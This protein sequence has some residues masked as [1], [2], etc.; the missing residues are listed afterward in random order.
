MLRGPRPGQAP[1]AAHHGAAAHAEGGPAPASGPPLVASSGGVP[2]RVQDPA[3]LRE[4]GLGG[5]GSGR[6]G[7]NAGEEWDTHIHTHTHIRVVKSI[8]IGER[9]ERACV[10]AQRLVGRALRLSSAH[11]PPQPP[12]RQRRAPPFPRRRPLRLRTHQPLRAEPVRAMGHHRHQ[13]L[14]A[15]TVTAATAAARTPIAAAHHETTQIPIEIVA[16][17]TE[18]EIAARETAI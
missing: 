8:T 9:E 16:V 5:G 12:Q 4:Y 2:G 3:Y 13:E 15:A 17:T 18:I 11:P 14:P 1:A 6:S 7:A 10:C